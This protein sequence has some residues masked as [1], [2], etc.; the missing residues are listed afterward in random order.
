MPPK[1]NGLN[2]AELVTK[3]LQA[4]NNEMS[5]IKNILQAELDTAHELPSGALAR[6]SCLEKEIQK[7]RPTISSTSSSLPSSK[8]RSSRICRHWIQ[9][10]CM[11]QENCK[12]SHGN[13]SVSSFESAMS[14][15]ELSPDSN[16][17]TKEPMTNNKEEVQQANNDIIEDA[18]TASMS[19]KVIFLNVKNILLVS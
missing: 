14:G 6:I 5:D 16:F 2:L 15:L 13:G 11:W 1:I 8:G 17:K 3:T 10:K 9:N 7:F 4:Q 18:D 12:F 19:D